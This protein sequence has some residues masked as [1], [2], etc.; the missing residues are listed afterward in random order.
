MICAGF[1]DNSMFRGRVKPAVHL[2]GIIKNPTVAIDNV[3]IM[4][5]GELKI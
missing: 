2:A 5:E 4:K 3:I 1:G